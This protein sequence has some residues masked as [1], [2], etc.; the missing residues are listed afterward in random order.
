LRTPSW[1][2]A[3]ISRIPAVFTPLEAIDLADRLADLLGLF[4]FRVAGVEVTQAIQ[5][6]HSSQ[7]LTDPADRGA[8]NAVT[9]VANKPAWIR[10][11]VRSGYKGGD[12]AGVTGT[13]EVQRRFGGLLYSTVTTLSPQ[14]PGAVTAHESAPYATERGT[15][16]SSLNFIAPAE[17]M[18][19]H[20]KLIVTATTPSGS[21]DTYELLLNAT[22]RQTLRLRG[23]MVGYNGPSSTATGAP[24][25]TLAA[26]TLADL[27]TTSGWALLTFPVRSAA[28]YSSAGAITLT[29]PLSDAPSCAGC[30]TPNWVA[31]N[32]QVAAQVT[33][34]GNNPD[35]LYYGL[36]ASGVP[37]GPIIGCES[38]G[39]SAGGVGNGVTMAHE[40]G[41]HCG[42]PHAPCGSVGTPD[43]TYP[44]YE[45]YD[46]SGTPQASIGEY[47]LDISNG[48]IKSPATFKDMMSYCGPKWIS[49]H[50]HG[51]LLNNPKLDP[52]RVC[53]DHPWWEDYVLYDPQLIPERWL[54]D[55][56]PDRW[57]YRRD[58]D[59]EPLISIIGVL[60]SER[61]LEVTSVMRLD[62]RPQPIG[63]SRS[64]MSAM[65]LDEDGGVIAQ[66]PVY[67]LR[68]QAAESGCGCD[69]EG[70]DSGRFPAV[71][72]ALV[73]DA[74]TGTALV[75]RR[76]D[77][78]LWAR[79]ATARAP[80]VREFAARVR[81]GKVELRWEVEGEGEPEIWV[82]WEAGER[83][84]WR[85]L[86]TGLTGEGA[87]LPISLLPPGS[88][89]LRL[90]AGDGFHTSV[91]K[92]VSVRVPAR[93]HD[94]AILT[95]RDG[96]TL[97]AE[98]PMR[99]HGVATDPRK[100]EEQVKGARWLL[101]RKE[102]AEGLDAFV[103]A[104]SPGRHRLELVVGRGRAPVR[105]AIEFVTVDPT[106]P[107]RRGSSE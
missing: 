44:A 39:V 60:R 105:T 99:L 68:S 64:R 100:P 8:D 51:K 97:V 26:P 7:H 59:P 28:T 83:G 90:L 2:G 23:V 89:R 85:A 25:L 57:K 81:Q 20:L 69:E 3:G 10:V 52:V 93:A 21:S 49:L 9:L 61:E 50:N 34:D 76:G 24:N 4:R 15:L 56:P 91:S 74:G 70:G 1:E 48:N 98:A 104:P 30:C 58:V 65:L 72:Q 79:K 78:E 92:M 46:P 35:V 43:P 5:Y 33:A 40:L 87:E 77:E 67:E 75:I 45:P 82:Q 12:I 36:I 37:M 86:A 107:A 32:A 27:Q 11:Y 80:R 95:P 13:V 71:V 22:L 102:A 73:P 41:H 6:Y 14:P 17:L 53:V 88:S 96:Q 55:P 38:S 42:F 31:L 16:S 84:D 106:R 62:T 66:A 18:C 54:P 101:D 19:G 63:G 47:G 103:P 94:V 29:V